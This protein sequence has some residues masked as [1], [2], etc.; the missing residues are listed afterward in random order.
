MPRYR[1]WEQKLHHIERLEDEVYWLREKMEDMDAEG[2]EY[3]KLLVH[4][5]EL[6]QQLYD[7]TED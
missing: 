6:E 1:T 3:A 5:E 2:F 7:L 4:V